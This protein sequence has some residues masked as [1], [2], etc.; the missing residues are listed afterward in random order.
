M[1]TSTSRRAL[2]RAFAALALLLLGC[3][4]KSEPSPPLLPPL[5]G[6]LPADYQ[7]EVTRGVVL[8]RILPITDGKP[9]LAGISNPLIIQLRRSDDP[10][11]VFSPLGADARVW[12]TE[13]QRPSQWRYEAPGLLA[14]SVAPT[15]YSGMLIGYPDPSHESAT[16]SSIPEPSSYLT[17]APLEIPPGQIV[18]IGDIELR[19][20]ISGVDR[21]LDKVEVTYAVRDEYDAAVAA[22]RTRYPQLADVPV[23]RRIAQPVSP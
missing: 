19:Q 21:L 10:T 23:E 17:F 15:S 18:Y 20:T 11:E 9:G 22:L 3:S 2:R 6:Q 14:M 8:A 4:S 13:S 7:P 1:H 5:A 12:T 16:P